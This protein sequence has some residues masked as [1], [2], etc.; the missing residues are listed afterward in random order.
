MCMHIQS[1]TSVELVKF[2]GGKGRLCGLV[3]TMYIMCISVV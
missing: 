3:N 1:R 2:T